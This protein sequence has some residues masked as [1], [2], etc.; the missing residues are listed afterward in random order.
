[1]VLVVMLSVRQ[2]ES[3]FVSERL[4]SGEREV[5]GV[6]IDHIHVFSDDI[7]VVVRFSRVDPKMNGADVDFPL[8]A[9]G[10]G[11][12]DD[13]PGTP[14]RAD[15]SAKYELEDFLRDFH[16]GVVEADSYLSRRRLALIPQPGDFERF[17]QVHLVRHD[18]VR[19]NPGDHKR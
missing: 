14:G 6:V 13:E 10:D 15:D 7:F 4:T 18:D 11:T 1:M 9:V 8:H 12:A 17:W 2:S 5:R 16:T 3:G 19:T